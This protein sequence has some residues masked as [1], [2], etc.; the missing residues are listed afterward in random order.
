MTAFLD[1]IFPPLCI[2]CKNRCSTRFLCPNCWHLCELPDPVDR[3]RHCFEELDERANLCKQCRHTALLS[4]VRGFV[5]DS[6]SPAR[7]LGLEATEAMAGFALIQWIQLEWPLPDAVIPMPDADSRLIARTFADWLQLPFV[8]V[9]NAQG[10][11]CED[12]IEEDLVL[13]VIDA[14][15]PFQKLREADQAL[16]EAF[17]KRTYILSLFSFT[18]PQ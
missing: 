8:K 3:C 17:P 10:K 2:A 12:L 15:N 5:F 4:S 11:Y 1:L 14:A 6:E 9:L 7:C 13:L 16:R 18:E